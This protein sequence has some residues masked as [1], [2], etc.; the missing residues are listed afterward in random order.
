MA[1]QVQPVTIQHTSVRSPELYG[2]LH[3]NCAV[4]AIMQTYA[5]QATGR[6]PG[7]VPRHWSSN[8][9]EV[10]HTDGAGLMLHNNAVAEFHSAVSQ[11][12]VPPSL[13]QS[14]LRLPTKLPRHALL[15]ETLR[16]QSAS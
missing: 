5:A 8:T 12:G 10:V 11:A 4:A 16:Q 2:A 1:T 6:M 14:W 13:W 9:T 15:M 7:V 3:A